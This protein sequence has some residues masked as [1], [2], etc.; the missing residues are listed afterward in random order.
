MPFD[1]GPAAEPLDALPLDDALDAR[2]VRWA[3]PAGARR[4]RADRVVDGD[5]LELA[6]LG[7]SRLIGVDTP[8]VHG[9]RECFGPRASAYVE[10]LVP[11]GT[12]VRYALGR[13]PRDRYGRALVTV[14]LRDG[15]ALNAL[16]VERGY[17]STLTI[18]P[19]TRYA[20]RLEALERDA[21]RDRRGLW[22][23]CA[24]G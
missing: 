22:R 1:R 24:R 17:A 16:L 20:S 21:R 23:S 15:R 2:A 10:R 13:D 6:G 18:A 3:V 9:G 4:A 12:P 8:E 11:P 5:T 19:N 7:S 14:W